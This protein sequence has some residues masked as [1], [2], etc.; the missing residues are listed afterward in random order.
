MTGGEL[1]ARKSWCYVID[2]KWTGE[3]WE[4]RKKDEIEGNYYLLDKNKH[5]ETLKRLDVSEASETLGVHLAVD[6][7]NQVQRKKTSRTM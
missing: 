7:N 2:F 5:K 6:G 4:Y 1:C 3:K